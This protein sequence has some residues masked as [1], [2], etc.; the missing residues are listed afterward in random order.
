MTK[1]TDIT[2]AD[3]ATLEEAITIKSRLL[4]AMLQFTTMMKTWGDKVDFTYMQFAEV[5]KTDSQGN[6]LIELSFSES[7]DLPRAYLSKED[8]NAIILGI[9]SQF[10][11]QNDIVEVKFQELLSKID[12]LEATQE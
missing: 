9:K 10:I 7:E 3:I 8:A 4:N 2:V 6:K 5:E 12:E 1:I 11:A